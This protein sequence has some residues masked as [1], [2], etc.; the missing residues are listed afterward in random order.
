[1]PHFFKLG[2][3]QHI[4]VTSFFLQPTSRDDEDAWVIWKF[5][6]DEGNNELF[7]NMSVFSTVEILIVVETLERARPRAR[8]IYE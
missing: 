1:M 7:R 4:S 6:L 2:S 8:S 5:Y 3:S